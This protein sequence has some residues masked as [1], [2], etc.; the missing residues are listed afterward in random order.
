[1]HT[2]ILVAAF[3]LATV[4]LL[5]AQPAAAKKSPREALQVFTDLIGA[6]KCTGTPNGTR[7]EKQKGFWTEKMHWEWQF[8]DKDAWLKIDFEKGKHFTGGE[9]RYSPAKDEY[10][11]TLTTVKNEKIT[12]VGTV[13]MRDTTKYI[14][15][16]RVTDK[17]TQRFVFKLLHDNVFNYSYSVKAEGRPL[18][19]TKWSVLAT[20]DGQS[21]AAGSSKPECIVSG[22]TGTTAVSYLGKTYYVCCSG[23]R[24][25]FNASPAKYV[26]EWEEK[27]KA[28][29]K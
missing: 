3:F 20:K 18:F 24:D 8:K 15:L 1:M 2:R 5:G 27:Q 14:T 28:K 6:W 21:F 19:S 29:K 23:C 11:L 10:T 7:E 22:G 9:V 12:Y 16:D 4:T 26:K 13:E 25:E 17:E